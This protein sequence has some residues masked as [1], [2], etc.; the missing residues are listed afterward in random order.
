M[1]RILT[2]HLRFRPAAVGLLAVV[3]LSLLLLNPRETFAGPI[4]DRL[5]EALER[6]DTR[7][8]KT[9]V[10]YDRVLPLSGIER[11][12]GDGR[13][14]ASR[15]LWRQLYEELRRASADP[16]QRPSAEA[17]IE[18]ARRRQDAV[19]LG[20][21][22]DGYERIRPDALERGAV[23]VREGQ[24]V[25]G[26]G[27]AFESRTAFAAAALREWTYRGAEVRF[28]L[29]R[30]DYFSNR[31][32]A[33]PRLEADLD[34]GLGFRAMNFD[35]PITAHYAATG[36]KTLRLRATT[37]DGATVEAALAFSVRA[38]AAPA[39]NDTLHVAGTIPYLGGVASG[40]AYV[41]L[42]PGR[43]QLLNPAV[44]V[45]GFDLDNSM[46]WDELYALLNQEN[47]IETLRA[48]GYDAV[49]LNFTDATDYLQRNAFVL[50]DLL[51]QISGIV[52]PQTTVALAGASMGGLVSRYA[53][54]YM[55]TNGLPHSVRTFISFDSPHLGADIPL[56]IQY[57]VNFFSTQSADAATFLSQLNRPAARQM[58]VYHYTDPAG[59][60]GQPDPLRGTF[61]A[62]LA[63][64]GE[65]PGQP[66]LVAIANGSDNGSGEPFAP[67]AQ[68][69]Q[70]SYSDLLVAITGNIWAVPNATSTKIFDGRL[71]ILFS[72][73]SQA[74]TVSG[75]QPYDNAPGGWR[76][77]MAQ[78]DSVAAPY[79]DIVA[80]YP[81]HCFI[82]TVSAL[83]YNTSD[84]FHDIAA[85]PDPVSNTPFDVVYSQGTNQE[86]VAITPQNAAWIRNEVE[87][88]VTGVGPIAGA[89]FK[90][91][92][93]W[94]NPSSGSVGLSF[95]LARPAAVDLQVFGV[96]GRLVA[97]LAH[98]VWSAGI[99]KVAWSG[100]DSRGAV[101]A[102]GVYFVRLATEEGV[103]TRRLVRFR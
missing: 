72:T 62:D 3:A 78:L 64:V 75:T 27:E 68:L 45:E 10:L 97:N 101:T 83:A 102:S 9:G 93:P 35:R 28:V 57:W 26:S 92:M 42:A 1:P 37:A 87:M 31:G 41:Y 96:D 86:H 59:T 91:R 48:D 77:S 29:D 12:A 22:F 2:P 81:N 11:F 24:L 94:P 21:V 73:T 52:G 80:F 98:G 99:H 14:V 103:M 58:L 17:L 55:E 8:L 82:P 89:D 100:R 49:V 7:D 4:E 63:A 19:P 18:R 71:R 39:P 84:L 69:V 6:L 33:A 20:V 30:D 36:T 50:V 51:Q 95:S 46:N 13:A 32:G 25:R 15:D 67:G 61:A 70:W 79:G 23:E 16:A 76:A 44:V 56:G 88:G 53:L 5:S 43:T 38:L 34:D 65:W 66:R 85:D 90:L 40:D 47:L 54:A 60:T 74:V